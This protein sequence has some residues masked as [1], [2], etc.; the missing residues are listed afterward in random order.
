L[1]AAAYALGYVAGYAQAE[2]LAR[3]SRAALAATHTSFT[4]RV[5]LVDHF[6]LLAMPEH[7]LNL[8]DK[9]LL[10]DAERETALCRRIRRKK[11]T[12]EEIASLVSV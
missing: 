8:L 1:A 6:L 9:V 5:V 11:R 3:T 12:D 2:A 10:V 4:K 7:G